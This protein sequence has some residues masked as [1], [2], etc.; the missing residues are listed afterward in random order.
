VRAGH[1]V[2]FTRADTPVQGICT[3]PELTAGSTTHSAVFVA[4]DLS[5]LDRSRRGAR[6]A[7]DGDTA[8]LDGWD[9]LVWSDGSDWT[10]TITRLN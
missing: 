9:F 8:H 7:D 4:P 2:V 10:T 3:R 1:R 6:V 5:A